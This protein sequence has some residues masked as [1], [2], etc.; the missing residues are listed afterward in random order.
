MTR[1]TPSVKCNSSFAF[2]SLLFICLSRDRCLYLFCYLSL[3]TSCTVFLFAVLF[4]NSCRLLRHRPRSM[5]IC[6]I[7]FVSDSSGSSWQP[8]IFDAARSIDFTASAKIRCE[9]DSLYYQENIQSLHSAL[10][11]TL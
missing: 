4:P 6:I 5:S 2:L 9:L 7:Y 10:N 3:G 8:T 11:T 1:S